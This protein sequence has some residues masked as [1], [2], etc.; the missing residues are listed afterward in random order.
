MRTKIEI[1][2]QLL[3]QAMRST[4]A[5]TKKEVVEAGLRLLVET[6]AQT[7]I[8]GLRG[9]V[10]WHGDLNESSGPLFKLMRAGPERDFGNF[11]I[12]FSPMLFSA[13]GMTLQGG[14]KGP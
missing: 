4:G 13:C 10:Q 6:H 14:G 7:G 12:Q 5:R 2:G 11:E 9:V 8:R 1:D 3:R